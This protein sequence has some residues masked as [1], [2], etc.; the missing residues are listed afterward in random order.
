VRTGE[1][2][3]SIGSPGTDV[4]SFGKIAAVL[5][6]RGSARV[7]AYEMGNACRRGRRRVRDF[8][9]GLSDIPTRETG[10]GG[11]RSGWG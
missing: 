2:L 11:D 3:P 9:V 10:I 5:A 4:S 7:A 6:G 8:G 1:K